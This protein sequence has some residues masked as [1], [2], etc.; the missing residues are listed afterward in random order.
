MS[1]VIYFAATLCGISVDFTYPAANNTYQTY[2]NL[3]F[4][5]DVASV[6]TEEPTYISIWAD[7]TK[8][9]SETYDFDA[10]GEIQQFSQRVN[11]PFPGNRD[12]Q[13]RFYYD[14]QYY[15]ADG[16]SLR[17]DMR[18]H[19]SVKLRSIHFW[20]VH[21]FG[22]NPTVSS[23][24]HAARVDAATTSRSKTSSNIDGVFGQCGGTD[25]TQFRGDGTTTLTPSYNPPGAYDCSDL[26]PLVDDLCPADICATN[27]YSGCTPLLNCLAEFAAAAIDRDDSTGYIAA[28]VF[29]VETT[30]CG[31]LGRSV[32]FDDNNGVTR[33][34]A[35]LDAGLAGDADDYTKVLAH[36]LMHDVVGHCDDDDSNLMTDGCDET[37][38]VSS[39]DSIRNLMCGGGQG[40]DL[41]TAQCT[42][43]KDFRWD[44]RN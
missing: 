30:L 26:G 35:I 7:G 36:E 34:F 25:R 24:F 40:R 32:S 39:T 13:F 5:G 12:A 15:E 43:L 33:S 22:T 21:H 2:D 8:V 9:G 3:L 41:T 44:D 19:A 1:I 28:H 31:E 10:I 4:E 14:G 23:G 38:C 20:N 16:D 42:I 18:L 11:W 29:N 27:N 6:L 37:E 17:T